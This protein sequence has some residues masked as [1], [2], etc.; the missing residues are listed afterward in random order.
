MDSYL[1]DWALAVIPLH[2]NQRACQAGKSMTAALHHL[3]VWVVK[4]VNQQGVFLYVEGA[5]NYT[6]FDYMCDA[7]VS[8]SEMWLATPLSGGIE[9]PWR[10]VWPQ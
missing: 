1:R 2:P 8:I 5:F 7:L 9:L 3:M 6:S 4:A 10:A